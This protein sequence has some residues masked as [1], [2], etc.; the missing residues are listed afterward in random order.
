LCEELS[1]PFH[2]SNNNRFYIMKILFCIVGLLLLSSFAF[3]G[4]FFET[5]SKLGSSPFKSINS[6]AQRITDGTCTTPSKTTNQSC[7][8]SLE[9]IGLNGC[10]GTT[11]NNG[12]VP[13]VCKFPAQG[14]PCVYDT[15][16]ATPFTCIGG[17][18][19]VLRAPSDPC[20]NSVQCYSGYCD[21]NKCRALAIGAQ[22][23]GSDCALGSFC[24]PT[25]AMCEYA[26]P[27]NASCGNIAAGVYFAGS[28][29]TV[30]VASLCNG[31]ICD[32]YSSGFAPAGICTEIQSLPVGAACGGAGYETCQ[33]GLICPS[34]GNAQSTCQVPPP[35]CND[36]SPCANP[37]NEI[38]EC[39][40]STYG[41]CTH[42]PC[43]KG[44][45]YGFSHCL[46]NKNCS[47]VAAYSVFVSGTCAN[48]CLSVFAGF[49]CCHY[50]TIT[51][52]ALPPGFSCDMTSSTHSSAEVI[53]ASFILTILLALLAW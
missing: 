15:D 24:N 51:G 34:T 40:N 6:L 7:T 52:Y 49:V 13:G 30:D 8:T 48:Q 29:Y 25:S 12:S 22:C 21:S 32:A 42:D 19:D 2:L 41:N 16:C 46:L 23:T 43:D 35:G 33:D 45:Y 39:S 47:L 3:G 53:I 36:V 17:I 37:V 5:F 27:V 9:C 11:V 20:N 4:E 38:C 14:T 44:N 26:L 50:T 10:I 28:A 18:C 1:A 31:S